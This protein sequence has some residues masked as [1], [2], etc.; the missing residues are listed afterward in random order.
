[1]S[2]TAFALNLIIIFCVLQSEQWNVKDTLDL[3]VPWHAYRICFAN[4]NLT[5]Q[6]IAEIR[7]SEI[8]T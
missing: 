4:I 5:G 8:V 2:G 6:Y 3:E 7:I 1:M